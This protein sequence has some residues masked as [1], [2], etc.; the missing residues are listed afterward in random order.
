MSRKKQESKVDQLLIA[1]HDTEINIGNLEVELLSLEKPVIAK[2][3]EIAHQKSRLKDIVEDLED[4]TSE[5]ALQMSDRDCSDWLKVFAF[6]NQQYAE[7]VVVFEKNK[8]N[9]KMFVGN[10]DDLLELVQGE[11]SE[12]HLHLLIKRFKEDMRS[13]SDMVK[14]VGRSLS[15]GTEVYIYYPEHRMYQLGHLFNKWDRSKLG[16]TKYI[17]YIPFSSSTGD[18]VE[19]HI[20]NV[21]VALVGKHPARI[22]GPWPKERCILSPKHGIKGFA[23]LT[24]GESTKVII[25]QVTEL[26]YICLMENGGQ[27][28]MPANRIK[29]L[30]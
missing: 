15:E 12:I 21:A 16:N 26:G 14:I 28:E 7:Y 18:E 10:E 8:I 17:D 22:E 2:K 11:I 5:I 13:K 29:L 1:K 19:V 6:H 25:L 24:S 23:L 3:K 9:G 20:K 27:V 30:N 4:C